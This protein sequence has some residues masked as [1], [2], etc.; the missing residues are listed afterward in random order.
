MELT[1]ILDMSATSTPALVSGSYGSNDTDGTPYGRPRST[2]IHVTTTG[3]AATAV[4]AVKFKI[5][6][7][8]TGATGTWVPLR[9]VRS[10]DASGTVAVEHSVAVTASTVT[11]D[12]IATEETRDWPFIRVEAKS[13]TADAAGADACAAWVLL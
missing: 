11:Y 8:R 4:T 3:K 12:G 10:G 13:V 2:L 7:S 1:K 9:C 6:G 5:M